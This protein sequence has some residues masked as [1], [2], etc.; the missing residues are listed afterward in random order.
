MHVYGEL[1]PCLL[2]YCMFPVMNG[3]AETRFGHGNAVSTARGSGTTYYCVIP[4]DSIAHRK[5]CDLELTVRVRV[6]DQPTAL[7]VEIS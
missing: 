2:A 3:E 5:I 4:A 6:R 1:L 7:V